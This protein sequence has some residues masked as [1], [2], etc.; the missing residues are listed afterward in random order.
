LG[1]RSLPRLFIT[2]KLAGAIFHSPLVASDD[3]FDIGRGNGPAGDPRH[4]LFAA[5]LGGQNRNPDPAVTK[6]MIAHAHGNNPDCTGA[7]DPS[8]ILDDVGFVHLHVHSSY[9]LRE[10]AMPVAK[11]A[12]LAVADAMPALAITDEQ[13]LRRLGVFRKTGE[14]ARDRVIGP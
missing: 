7:D 3:R 14:S 10:G 8:R 11:L 13:P 9:S 6:A 1:A 5:T 4:G 2:L 12:R